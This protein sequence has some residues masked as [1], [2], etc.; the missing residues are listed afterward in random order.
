MHIHTQHWVQFTSVKMATR[1]EMMKT[2][3][4]YSCEQ[5]MNLSFI[6][7]W[8]LNNL[9]TDSILS[10][11]NETKNRREYFKTLFSKS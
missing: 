4:S 9:M 7:T 1:F 10:L 6:S 11:D 2:D 8:E 5:Y 3:H